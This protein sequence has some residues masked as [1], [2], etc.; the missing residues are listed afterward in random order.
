MTDVIR[1]LLNAL[2]EYPHARI[3]VAP[4]L[5]RLN[6][7]PDEIEVSGD[8]DGVSIRYELQ[9][10]TCTDPKDSLAYGKQIV[11]SLGDPGSDEMVGKCRDIL[12]A[13]FYVARYYLDQ[14]IMPNDSLMQ[15]YAYEVVN[16]IP[17]AEIGAVVE[18]LPWSVVILLDTNLGEIYTDQPV[19]TPDGD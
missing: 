8:V 3:A 17:A 4:R 9:R 10:F 5:I 12:A 16:R 19:Y 1:E 13:N 6:Q 14:W 2:Q 7:H 11:A 18:H 15:R